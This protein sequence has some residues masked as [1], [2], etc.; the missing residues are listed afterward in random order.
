MAGVDFID[1]GPTNVSNMSRGS[2]SPGGSLRLDPATCGHTGDQE[3]AAPMT[4]FR[5]QPP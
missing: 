2:L 3:L 1:S 5:V 4:G